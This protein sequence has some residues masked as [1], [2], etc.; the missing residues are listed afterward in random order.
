[1]TTAAIIK[2]AKR[3]RRVRTP[4]VLQMEAAECGAAALAIVLGYFRCF[5]P[6]EKLREAC[7]V[8]RDGS[9]AGSIVKAAKHYGLGARGFRYDAAKA[10][11]GSFPS[12]AFWN[13][14]HFVVVEGVRKGRV[15]L[16]DP[17]LGPRAVST[18][19]FRDAYSGIL[20]T[21]TKE[22]NFQPGGRPPAVGAYL[23]ALV[24]PY[25]RQMAFIGVVGVLL[26][27]PGF[28]L[29]G[30][31]A[32]FVDRILI[33]ERRDWLGPLLLVMLGGAA[34][35]A[36]LTWLKEK[37][38]LRLQMQMSLS[39]S[40]DFMWH[41]L[42][43]PAGFFAQRYMGDIS[44]RVTS[45]QNVAA[46]LAGGVGGNV[47]E[48]FTAVIVVVLMT[49]LSPILTLTTVAASLLN[50]I[51]LRMFKRARSDAAIRMQTDGSKLF[52]TS[53]IGLRTIETLKATGSEDDYFAKWAGYHARSVISEQKMARL[54]QTS[55]IVPGLL[56]GLTTAFLLG[57]GGLEVMRGSLTLGTLIAFQ[58]L[59]GVISV[60]IQG[61][62]ATAG[63]VQQAGADMARLD[64]VFC[65]PVDWRH[66]PDEGLTQAAKEGRGCGEG[67]QLVN[68]SFGYNKT[69]KPLIEDFSLH[70]QPGGRVALVGGSGS[71][72]STV[73][74]LIAGLF[75]PW[76]GEI[77][78]DGEPMTAYDRRRLASMVAIVDQE[79]ALFR[80]TVRE[81]IALWEK[82]VP[83]ERLVE[84]AR[85]AQLLEMIEKM[86][87]NFDAL[88]DEAGRNLSGGQ[89]Q[90]V[91][92]A[93]ALY[94]EP[95]LLVLDEATSAL[96]PITELAV[97]DAVR[98]RG[99]ACVIVAHR[100]STIRD[101]DE[102]LVLERGR[103]VER[104]T[105]TVLAGCGGAYAR[106][107]AED[108]G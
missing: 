87:G 13:F 91:E 101:A 51:F 58:A 3:K 4:T 86:P 72:K 94:A 36:I 44:N 108:Q 79:I 1:L 102:I 21:F 10:L 81:N 107:I 78:L 85:S 57:L 38:L 9:K 73:A 30:L 67:L 70:V 77:L 105:H 20:L 19:E 98:R 31:N 39:R 14:N 15:F 56:A 49:S 26:A 18:D 106:L 97:M 61:L 89:R 27:V 76:T 5:V 22:P 32:I 104:G 64:D 6:L 74:K 59:F 80:A 84:A 50:V 37:H 46:L 82:D 103:I 43:L 48:T 95:A 42:T 16:N 33:G 99:M 93:R 23:R 17:A 2:G 53:V 83:H 54:S 96:D 62:I 25:A 75:R 60:P 35:L 41:V 11:E 40:A 47:A 65:Y 34:V 88:V 66:A 92:I 63:Q 69:E 55:A 24:R 68:V 8:S 100:L 7:G 12:I 52:A 29:P 45:V 90:R 28:V 71:G